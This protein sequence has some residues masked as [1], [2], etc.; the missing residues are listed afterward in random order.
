MEV[1][2]WNN[3]M[4]VNLERTQKLFLKN[5]LALPLN[6]SAALLRPEWGLPSIWAQVHIPLINYWQKMRSAPV[7]HLSSLCFTL[8]QKGFHM[9]FQL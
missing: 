8:F 4:V 9:V 2:G 3:A 7:C 5:I 6:T 1:R